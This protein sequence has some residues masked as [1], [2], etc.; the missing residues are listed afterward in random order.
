MVLF[1][2]Q[3]VISHS[4]KKKLKHFSDVADQIKSIRGIGYK[5]E[6]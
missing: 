5:F 3:F 1:T 2:E 4:L 6:P